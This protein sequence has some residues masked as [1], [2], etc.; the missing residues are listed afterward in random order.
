MSTTQA[1]VNSKAFES[2]ASWR[3]WLAQNH[4]IETN[5]WIKIYKKESKVPSVTYDQAVDE[6]LCFGWIDSSIKKGNEQYFYQFFS[7]R[8]PKSNWSA[9]NKNMVEVLTSLGK[10]EVSGQTMIDLAKK[11][12]TWNALDDVENLIYPA[13]LNTA[14][15]LEQESKVNF[16]NFPRSIK[17]GIL[18]WL[19]N[20]KL[21]ETRAKRINEIVKKAAINERA[22][23]YIKK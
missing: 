23:Q 21:P 4:Q 16:D 12:G 10:M 5:I 20:G 7:K 19:F 8:N 1:I 9:V 11:T 6:A 15:E 3:I 2:A 17:R 18:E 13:D 22:N 14:F